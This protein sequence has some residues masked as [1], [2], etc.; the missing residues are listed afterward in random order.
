M[1]V[2]HVLLLVDIS[3]GLDTLV[4]RA[5]LALDGLSEMDTLVS[6]TVTLPAALMV[7]GAAEDQRHYN[8]FIFFKSCPPLLG[9][10]IA[11]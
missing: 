4:S 11:Q 2:S 6:R 8:R 10:S 1:L 3:L 9:C 7:S 5:P